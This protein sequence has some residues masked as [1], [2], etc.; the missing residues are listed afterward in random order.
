MREM[1]KIIL[2]LFLC[3]GYLGTSFAAPTNDEC[4]TPIN[5]TVNATYIATASVCTGATASVGTDL[6]SLGAW[7][8][9]PYND[10]W[11]TV[12][13]PAGGAVVIKTAVNTS[14]YVFSGGMAVYAG[15]CGAFTQK[16][17]SGGN[18]SSGFPT[19]TIKGRTVGE[20]LYVRFWG[21]GSYTAGGSFNIGAFIPPVN[22]DCSGAKFIAT[23]STYIPTTQSNA[24]ATASTGMPTACGTSPYNDVWFKTVVPASGKMIVK[25]DNSDYSISNL[26]LAV[27]K[28]SNCTLSAYLKC[29]PCSTTSGFPV[30]SITTGVTPGDTLYV[31]AWT[32]TT[33]GN[34]KLGIYEPLPNDECSGATLVPVTKTPTLVEYSLMGATASAGMPGACGGAVGSFK[35]VWFKAVVPLSGKVVVKISNGTTSPSLFNAGAAA[36][37]TG[38]CGSMTL[39]TGGCFSTSG[40]NAL[41]SLFGLTSNDTLRIRVWTTSTYAFDVNFNMAVYEP[42]QNDLCSGAI[43][44]TVN[45]SYSGTAFNS[46][47]ALPSTEVNPSCPGA[48]APFNDVWFSAIVPSNGLLNIKTE[49]VTSTNMLYEAGIAAYTGICGGGL[50]PITGGCSVSTTGQPTPLA[51]TGLT[52]LSTVYIRVWGTGNYTDGG[53]FKIGAWAPPPPPVND[54]CTTAIDLPVNPSLVKTSIDLTSATASV[55]APAPSCGGTITNDAWFKVTIPPSKTAIINVTKDIITN[56]D[57]AS[58]AIYIAAPGCASLAAPIACSNFKTLRN[59]LPYIRIENKTPGDVYYVR[60]WSNDGNS[61]KFNIGAFVDSSAGYI[62]PSDTMDANTKYICD[63][64]GFYGTSLGYP[65]YT[66][67]PKEGTLMSGYTDRYNPNNAYFHLDSIHGPKPG[68]LFNSPTSLENTSWMQFYATSPNMTFYVTAKNCDNLYPNTSGYSPNSSSLGGVQIAFLRD[69]TMAGGVPT[70]FCELKNGATWLSGNIYNNTIKQKFSLVGLTVGKVYYILVDG[71]AGDVCDY[72]VELDK[73]GGKPFNSGIKNDIDTVSVGQ[74]VTATPYNPLKYVLNWV[75]SN[76]NFTNVVIGSDPYNPTLSFNAP[77]IPGKYYILLNGSGSAKCPNVAIQDTLWIIVTIPNAP[78]FSSGPTA[79][80]Q[81]TISSNYIAS[82][83]TYPI[84][85]SLLPTTA[86]TIDVNSGVVTWNTTFTGIAHVK[87]TAGTVLLSSIRD[88]TVN[89][90]PTPTAASN[91]PVCVGSPLNLS[92]DA[93]S[94]YSWSGPNSYTSTSITPAISAAAL[95]NAGTYTVTVTDINGCT[96]TSITPVV[97]NALPNPNLGSDK[98]VCP[99]FPTTLT[100]NGGGTYSWS[101]SNSGPSINVTP[102]DTTTYSVTVTDAKGC[103]ASESITVNV[104]ANLTPKIRP[105]SLPVVCQGGSTTL[106]VRNY[107]SPSYSFLWDNSP[108]GNTDSIVVAPTTTNTKYSVTVTDVGGGCTGTDAII[109]TVQPSITVTTNPDTICAGQSAIL[110]AGTDQTQ[111][112]AW[113]HSS[114][115][116]SQVTVSPLTT[117]AY[118]VTVTKG[119]CTAVGPFTVTVHQLPNVDAGNNVGICYGLQTILTANGGISYLWSTTEST[120]NIKVSPAT[121]T[122][123]TVTV[124]DLNK[125][126]S[127]DSVVVDVYST[128]LPVATNTGPVCVGSSVSLDLTTAFSTYKWTGNNFTSTTKTA[129]VSAAAT[130]ANAGVYSVTVTDI[131]GCSNTATTAIVVNSNPTPTA[132]SSPVCEGNPLTLSVGTYSGYSWS[133]PN[134]TAGSIPNPTVTN[135]ASILANGGTYFV[136]VTDNHG[137]TNTSSVA[138]VI[139]K[140]PTVTFA[141]LGNVCDNLPAFLLTGG[142]PAGGTYYGTGVMAGSFNPQ[143]N[144]AG[145]FGLTY[146]YQDPTTLCTNEA[147]SQIKIIAAPT[148]NLGSD[149]TICKG[150]SYILNTGSTGYTYL[151]STAEKTPTITVSTTGTYSVTL[152][153]A[154]GSINDQANVTVV[155]NPEV[156]LGSDMIGCMK[157]ITLAVPPIFSQYEWS[158]GENT[159]EIVAMHAGTYSVKV[160]DNNGCS[161]GDTINLVDSCKINLFIPNAFTPNDDGRNDCFVVHIQNIT[162]YKIYIYNKWG[163]L[164]YYSNN[165]NDCWDGRFKGDD[166]QMGNYYYIITYKG[167]TKAETSVTG[168]ILLL[169]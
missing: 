48:I 14:P 29:S 163:G 83:L 80:C 88:V 106:T 37:Y 102:S 153:S 33:D 74:L 49:T 26:G 85:Y 92:V 95:A 119:V 93:Y 31:R 2:G 144:G 122:T 86:G 34:F 17:A 66:V 62:R 6:T 134:F 41:I 114:E 40:A 100:A 98:T 169:R 67:D 138:V 141:T 137:C 158:T 70:S 12:T 139:N 131:N 81:G 69:S 133:G 78:V 7:G 112:Y 152:T 91:S 13:V 45:S 168:N 159:N 58:M 25:T 61:K 125:C 120:Q 115:T 22:D 108:A 35:D 101:N 164:V 130:N 146:S 71:I 63:L 140:N 3:I 5:L 148:L 30:I 46:F 54:D 103:S 94:S 8:A 143:Q 155:N 156:S 72:K 4:S 76:P 38:T 128:P 1:K 135:T 96:N 142:S 145:T 77:L 18:A 24:G 55:G 151:W 39:V 154:C 104:S 68:Y 157:N 56:G 118:T 167:I 82:L 160:Y 90:K 111:S 107:S 19:L 127:K 126:A 59:R 36:V 73:I 65:D 57:S 79:I 51:L 129:L 84:T 16:L 109:I 64:N 132:S 23:N 47:G 20:I 123:Y 15:P 27:Y 75:V 9:G 60:L 162:E 44:L 21:T 28:G 136:T 10:V 53:D 121:R 42:L 32:N 124:T 147:S 149:K 50:T 166:C 87:A 99:S 117:T 97:V 110:T 89:S 116:T 165:E 113:S 11:F 161:G 52:P 43:A 105:T 150:D